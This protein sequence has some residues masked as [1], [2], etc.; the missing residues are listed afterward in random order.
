VKLI[1]IIVPE[2]AVVSSIIDTRRCFSLANDMLIEQGRSPLF[3]VEL[4][5]FAREM[6]LDG[7]TVCLKCDRTTDETGISDLVIIPAVDGDVVRATQLNRHYYGW[8][9][10]QYK[11][12]AEI[13]S[14]CLGSFLLAATGL[15]KN[16]RT[17]THW[18]FTNEFRIFYPDVD[19]IDDKII[20]EQNGIF[21]SGGGISYWNLV[22]YLLERYASRDIVL[23]V[24][25][26]FLLDMD[27]TSQ[28]QFTIFKGQKAHGDA[29]VLSVQEYI[30]QNYEEKMNV[31]Q[32]AGHFS[33]VRRTLE[34]RFKKA[35]KNTISE[36]IQRIKVEAAKKEI[37]FGRKTVQEIIYELG[38]TDMKSF[39]DLFQTITGLTP[40]EYKS[41]FSVAK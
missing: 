32:I 6:W 3:Q 34:R 4:V 12:G 35:T 13:A 30:E 38:Y 14:Y 17:A 11:S 33:I 31:D 26:F 20:S 25:K 36:Y 37:E 40:I 24:S 16:K 10:R 9:I 27:R 23:R 22:L 28:S 41:K 39:R 19:L 7:G 29:A 8:I 5:G 2:Q 21:T 18:M 1:S 15:L